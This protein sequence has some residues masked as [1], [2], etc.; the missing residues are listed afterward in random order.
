[1]GIL[2]ARCRVVI[3]FIGGGK[4]R[5][6]RTLSFSAVHVMDIF[7]CLNKGSESNMIKY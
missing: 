6:K 4:K 3:T 5:L 7:V 1:M 2:F